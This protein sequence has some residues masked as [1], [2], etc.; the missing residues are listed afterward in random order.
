MLDP[1]AQRG[2]AG[3]RVVNLPDCASVPALE[4]GL[5]AYFSF[6]NHDRPH[7]SLNYRAP[8]EVHFA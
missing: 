3:R 2:P 5:Q 8:A 7:Q 4:A 1:I 6:Y